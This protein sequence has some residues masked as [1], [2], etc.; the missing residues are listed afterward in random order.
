MIL[1]LQRRAAP[2]HAKPLSIANRT[3]SAELR[4]PSFWRMIDEVLATVARPCSGLN[5]TG[6]G[7]D[8]RS[9]VPF[10]D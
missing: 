3:S 1:R 2:S 9:C 10:P 7:A 6:G 4:T 5:L 8:N